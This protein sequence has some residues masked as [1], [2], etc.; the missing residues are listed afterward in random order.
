MDKLT[1]DITG[2]TANQNFKPVDMQVSIYPYPERVLRAP[3]SIYWVIY[4]ARSIREK[5][6]YEM[7]S[8]TKST[9]YL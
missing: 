1:N 7:L 3:I 5:A 2:D 9:Y 6:F 4:K 8:V